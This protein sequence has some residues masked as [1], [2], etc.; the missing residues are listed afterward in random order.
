MNG[1]LAETFK[2]LDSAGVPYLVLRPGEDP[3]SG[4][5]L[6]EVDLLVPPNQLKQLAASLKRQGFVTLPSWGRAPHRFFVAYHQA[7]GAWVEF[8]VVTDLC[9]GRPLPYLRLPLRRPCWT[10]RQARE[11]MYVPAAEDELVSLLLNCLV[12]KGHFKPRH[13]RRLWELRR[14]LNPG[15]PATGR[16]DRLSE[17]MVACGLSWHRVAFAIDQQD[18]PGLLR[19]GAAVKRRLFWSAPIA[20]SGRWVSNWLLRRMLPILRVTFHPG[21]SVALLGPDG[22]G[23]TSLAQSLAHDLQL[24]ARP[25]YM[26]GNI[27][28]NPTCLPFLRWVK[29]LGQPRNR[30]FSAL[31]KGPR[32]AARLAEHGYRVSAAHYHMLRGRFVIFDR[33]V[34]DSWLHPKPSNL[35]SRLRRALLESGWPTPDLV[36]VLDAP[37]EILHARKKEHS[38]EWLEDRR[39]RYRSLATRIP[40][41]R[42]VDAT[43]PE[44]DVHREVTQLIWQRYASLESGKIQRHWVRR[45]LPWTAVVLVVVALALALALALAPLAFHTAHNRDDSAVPVL[46]AYETKPVPSPGDAADAPAV[47]ANPADP[48]R[49]SI[50]STDKYAATNGSSTGAT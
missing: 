20:N 23:K 18:W 9:Y 5:N 4:R 6:R 3:H 43:R 28:T 21:L 39:Q 30:L 35:M 17:Y 25:I 37:G 31:L 42:V 22:A 47:W 40:Q 19:R 48:S 50:I 8:D 12:D 14:E 15:S 49:S 27:E 1:F 44:S 34:H 45:P 36:I 10:D 24:R 33:F 26:G 13:K 32:L 11:G 41:M 46:A 2:A 29:K 7:S 16:H 38:P